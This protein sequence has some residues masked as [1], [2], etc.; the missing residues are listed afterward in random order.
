MQRS[1]D[2]KS[3][4]TGGELRALVTR[5]VPQK[6]RDHAERDSKVIRKEAL[7]IIKS[8]VEKDFSDP[9]EQRY[10]AMEK[11]R[12]GIWGKINLE[13]RK[14]ILRNPDADPSKLAGKALAEW[15]GL[16]K[17]DLGLRRML[18][19]EHLEVY[20]GMGI[21]LEFARKKLV[22]KDE[23][24]DFVCVLYDQDRLTPKNIRFAMMLGRELGN[25]TFGK[26]SNRTRQDQPS[27]ESSS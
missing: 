16:N 5:L 27:Q 6:M 14:E 7:A 13:I 19:S 23:L 3:K 8:A 24:W 4:Q 17:A 20:N 25:K 2:H 10:L 21:L 9:I 22:P 15:D 11:V 26:Q 12:R 1:I 18:S